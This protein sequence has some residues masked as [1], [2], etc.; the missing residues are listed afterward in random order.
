MTWIV[1]LDFRAQP[2]HFHRQ[3]GTHVLYYSLHSALQHF[4]SC[5]SSPSNIVKVSAEFWNQVLWMVIWKIWIKLFIDQSFIHFLWIRFN[6]Y[7]N[8]NMKNR[9]NIKFYNKIIKSHLLR[10]KWLSTDVM[11][12]KHLTNKILRRS[13]FVISIRR[14]FPL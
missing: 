5:S 2:S 4:T 1:E 14:F 8:N 11:S 6:I 12:N 3:F 7:F 10:I 13:Y 9:K